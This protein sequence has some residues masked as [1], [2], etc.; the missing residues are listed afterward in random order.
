[1]QLIEI[2][3][4]AAAREPDRIAFV[5]PDGTELT[6]RTLTAIVEETASALISAGVRR[7][8]TVAVFS[9]NDARAFAA[10]LA[11]VRIGA[12]W[13]PLNPRNTADDNIALANATDAVF[14]FF[15]RRFEAEI[16]QLK[17]AAGQLVGFVCLDGESEEGLSLDAFRQSGD[18]VP[19]AML[20]ED[21][22][23]ACNIFATGGTTG[24][25]K[26]AVWSNQTW[27]TLIANF[28]T[29]A[30]HGRQPV[31]LCVA[32][33][34]HGAGIL[35]LMLM[36]AAPTNVLMTSAE[37]EDILSAIAKHR[38][39]HLFLP[40]TVLYRLLSSEALGKYDTS[41]ITFFLISAAP[42]SADKLREAVTAFGP[43][44]CQ[45]FGQAEAPFFAAFL[46]AE[47]HQRALAS[48]ADA[49]LLRSCGRPT[50]FTQLEIMSD[51]GQLLPP[52]QVGELVVTGNLRMAGYYNDPQSTAA[53]ARNGW[54]HTGDVGFK[55]EEG[56]FYIVDRKR[57]MIITGGFNVFSTEVEATL[58]AHPAVMDC[59]VIGVPDEKWGEA[60]TAIIELKPDAA[61]SVADLLAH[62][63]EKLGGVK[64]PKKIEIWESLPRSPV[65]KV[66]K[67]AVRDH[68]WA[69]R[70]R[71]V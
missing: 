58:L 29:C 66:L 10:M 52:N 54:H 61:V 19:P 68:F 55:D 27:E 22:K 20:E 33:M 67:R 11:I 12:V 9:A 65:G 21:S 26:G 6:Y 31:H 45:S 62:A 30:A 8:H 63:R 32:P 7:G 39:T 5:Q 35:A 3:R 37:P 48:E 1:M 15:Q 40:P 59:A 28:W 25:S 71:A 34:T 60:V 47:D 17:A 53:I 36:P 18:Q 56:Y 13:V 64:C 23:R 38:V 49:R 16:A 24:R 43:V 50:M 69:G 41:S 51:D 14:I 46:S 44:M 57:D 42:V 70:E 2:Y 4:R